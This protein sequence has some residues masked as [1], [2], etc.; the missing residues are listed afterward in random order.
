MPSHSI[1]CAT[2]PRSVHIPPRH[3]KYLLSLR[4]P[5]RVRDS[6]LQHPFSL[7]SRRPPRPVDV[8]RI[9]AR[10]PAWACSSVRDAYC[11][12]AQA[13]RRS[14]LPFQTFHHQPFRLPIWRYP[15]LRAA[16]ARGR[17]TG[18]LTLPTPRDSVL[19]A[20]ARAALPLRASSLRPQIATSAGRF[21]VSLESHAPSC[22]QR[23]G[24]RKKRRTERA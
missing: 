13:A 18:C 2:H 21:P 6:S 9:R 4:Q 7:D 5:R 3:L 10:P 20:L 16:G 11:R 14:L 15:P 8:T 24:G 12:Q 22:R 1:R 23:W 17:A 19:N